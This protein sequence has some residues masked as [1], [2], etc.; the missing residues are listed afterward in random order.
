VVEALATAG[1]VAI[2]SALWRLSTEHAG[3][4]VALEQGMKAVVE[5][6]QS[7][8]VELGRDVDRL[9]DVLEDHESRIRRLER[10]NDHH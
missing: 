4:R 9:E 3:M 10:P 6:I 1:V 7:L 5:Q 2:V 8:R